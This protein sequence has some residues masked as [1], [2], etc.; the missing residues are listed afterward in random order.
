MV[1]LALGNVRD[2][3]LSDSQLADEKCNELA[4]CGH[5][6]VVLASQLLYHVIRE[7]AYSSHSTFGYHNVNGDVKQ[8]LILMA[9][10]LYKK[11]KSNAREGVRER[12]PHELSHPHKETRVIIEL[13]TFSCWEKFDMT[14]QSERLETISHG[15]DFGTAA[16]ICGRG[17]SDQTKLCWRTERDCTT[18]TEA[19]GIVTYR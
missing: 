1:L 11:S 7:M 13:G 9:I 18:K 14:S 2:S 4:S 19:C 6:L 10:Q 17:E 8:L 16:R 15:E 3:G 12:H 5:K